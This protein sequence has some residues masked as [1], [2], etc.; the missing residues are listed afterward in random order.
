MIVTTCDS[1]DGVTALIVVT[2]VAVCQC[3]S[4]DRVTM[5]SVDRE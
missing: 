5:L 1:G 2:A 4:G 3:D